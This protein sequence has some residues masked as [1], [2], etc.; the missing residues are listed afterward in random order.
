MTLRLQIVAVITLLVV[1]TT[2]AVGLLS[3][4][5]AAQELYQENA[6]SL[7]AAAAELQESARDTLARSDLPGVS[8]GNVAPSAVA[9]VFPE[10]F[11]P[12]FTKVLVQV[13]DKRASTV[14][15]PTG[16]ELPVSDEDRALAL[17]NTD[18]VS[19]LSEVLIRGENYLSLTAAIPGGG[20]VQLA[21]SLS[22]RDRVLGVIRTSTFTAVVGAILAGLALSWVLGTGVVLRLMRLTRAVEEVTE[23]GDLAPDLPSPGRDEA[24]RLSAAFQRMLKALATSREQQQRLVQDVGHELRTPLTS[25]RTN[26]EILQQYDNLEPAEKAAILHDVQ[27]ESQAL[28]AL[29]EEVVDIASGRYISDEP[30]EVV[31]SDVASAAA[32]QVARRHG[33]DILVSGDDGVVYISESGLTRAISNLLENAVKYSPSETTIEVECF[34]GC[35]EVLDRGAGISPS[36]AE[37]AFD[38]FF[39]SA[40]Q[41][42]VPGSGLGLAIVA[43]IVQGA[44]GS[45]FARSRP[46]GG[47][48]F[49][50]VLPHDD[51]RP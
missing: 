50:F 9:A 42:S 32:R 39:R 19:E 7:A 35:L 26:L 27:A 13:L 44:S 10:R 29:V 14:L 8:Y 18:A 1:L 3:Y 17:S 45:V 22:E 43:D 48:V 36:D 51:A 24:G 37:R 15:F 33:R 21:R 20:A 11:S 5:T 25:L 31:L 34:N 16:R 6:D 41:T 30:Q 47:S 2:S 4:R 49:G 40:T 28:T 12:Q 38:R 46:D 23:T